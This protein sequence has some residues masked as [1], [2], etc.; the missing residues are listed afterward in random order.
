MD[1][2][3]CDRERDELLRRH[4]GSHFVFTPHL[5]PPEELL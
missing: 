3:F 4:T 2:T 1:D 5:K